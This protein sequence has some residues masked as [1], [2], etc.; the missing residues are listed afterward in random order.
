[1]SARLRSI[2]LFLLL[3]S[4]ASGAR[5]FAEESTATP[6]PKPSATKTSTA[7]VADAPK[8]QPQRVPRAGDVQRVF[9]VHHAV[10]VELARL[11]SVFPATITY[12]GGRTRAI[13]VSAQPAVMA[14]I[15]ET[16]KRLDVSEA[17]SGP[18]TPLANIELTGYVVEALDRPVEGARVPDELAPAVEQL[19]H[20]FTYAA[21]RLV[22]T[23]IARGREGA[24]LVASALGEQ[25]PGNISA[26]PQYRL[27]VSRVRVSRA[28]AGVAVHLDGFSFSAKVPVQ[29]G[30]TAGGSYSMQ[31]VG[32]EGDLDIREGQ[33]VVVGKSGVGEAGNAIILVLTA[34]VVD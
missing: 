11:L 4:L 26:R 13:A 16:L 28:A 5:G 7:E 14:A 6:P 27:R 3:G 24:T 34:K 23:L 18:S 20:T 9:E 19:K 21:Y 1:M 10:P 32:V 17:G 31:E 15:E 8:V 30:L 12:S 22:D 33:K 2:L 29:V 25:K